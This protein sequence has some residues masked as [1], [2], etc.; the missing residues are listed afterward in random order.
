[1]KSQVP[2]QSLN[3]HSRKKELGKPVTFLNY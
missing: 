2:V 3:L 1:M